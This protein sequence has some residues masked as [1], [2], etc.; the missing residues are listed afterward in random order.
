MA[1]MTQRASS[2][3]M[4]RYT[5]AAGPYALTLTV[6]P[7]GRFTVDVADGA[8][9]MA[10]AEARV[11][12]RFSGM[13]APR[14]PV[15]VATLSEPNGRIAGRYATTVRLMPGTYIV[16]IDVDGHVGAVRIHLS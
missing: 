4:H 16:R 12:L 2:P 13:S 8:M 3:G 5:A 7:Q 15:D 14:S 6:R 9:G 1:G 10:A 11:S